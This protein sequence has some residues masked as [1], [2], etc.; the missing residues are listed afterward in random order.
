[1]KLAAILFGRFTSGKQEQ[2]DAFDLRLI[3]L[4]GDA[5]KKARKIAPALFHRSARLA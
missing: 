3:S 4:G 5:K 2:P 1:M